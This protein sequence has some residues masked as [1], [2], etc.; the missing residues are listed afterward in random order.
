MSSRHVSRIAALQAL[1]A[2]DAVGAVAGAADALAHNRTAAGSGDED[3]A[4]TDTLIA[5]VTAKQPEIDAVITSAAP[6][7]PLDRIAPID[8]NILRLGL[9]ELLYTGAAVPHKVAVDEAIELAKMFGGDTS[10]SF[11]GGVLGGVYSDLVGSASGGK[12]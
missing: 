2:A 5:G 12:E 1:F 7:W 6:E 9:Y 3:T 11:V 8:R 4:F 10:G